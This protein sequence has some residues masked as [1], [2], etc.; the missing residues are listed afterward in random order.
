MTMGKMNDAD[1]GD[2]N[3]ADYMRGTVITTLLSDDDE[4]G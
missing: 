2:G 4:K 3:D 1:D